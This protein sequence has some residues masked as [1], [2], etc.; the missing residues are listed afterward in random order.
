MPLPGWGGLEPVIYSLTP[1]F[2]FCTNKYMA[3]RDLRDPNLTTIITFYLSFPVLQPDDRLLELSVPSSNTA[4][5]LPV[6]S[7]TVSELP[8]F[9]C[10]ALSPLQ[11]YITSVILAPPQCKQNFFVPFAKYIQ[12]PGKYLWN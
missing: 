3:P 4:L 2:F 11:S 1:T 5:P 8:I 10:H 7:W 6:T 9:P 12:N